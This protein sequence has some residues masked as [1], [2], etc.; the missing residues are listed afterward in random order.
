[1]S[2]SKVSISPGVRLGRTALSNEMA[3]ATM[4]AEKL[5]PANKKAV[6]PLALGVDPPVL[7]AP[8]YKPFELPGA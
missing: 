7:L 5:V 2:R 3:P 4:G 6:L 1:M 8:T